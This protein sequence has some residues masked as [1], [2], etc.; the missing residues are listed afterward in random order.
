MFWYLG[1]ALLLFASGFV[2]FCLTPFWEGVARRLGVLDRPGPHKHQAE[3]VPY[4]GGMAMAGGFLAVMAAGLIGARL[5][6]AGVLPAPP[7]L[8]P[9]DLAG[10][11]LVAGKLAALL[12]G[13]LAM[14]LL[15]LADDLCSFKPSIKLIA[16]IV[17]CSIVA[18]FYRATFFAA[19]PLVG[20]LLTVGWLVVVTNIVNLLD[21]TDGAAA[22]ICAISALAFGAAAL[23]GG[24]W[25]VG[26]ALSA[27]AG[28]A[29]GFLPWNWHPARI[30][31]GDAG[32]LWLGFTI[33]SLAVLNTYYTYGQATP[34]AAVL[35][36]FVLAVPLFDSVRVVVLRMA[37][38][39]PVWQGDRRHLAHRL[40]EMGLPVGRA[41]GVLYLLTLATAAPALLL[42][43]LSWGGVACLGLQA[44]SVLLLVWAIEGGTAP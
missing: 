35:P 37:H 27:V 19:H 16:Q 22:G 4:L 20:Y 1:C 12:L 2:S 8:S 6:E 31:M 10:V 13:G 41:V 17:I 39:V 5:L 36:V 42:R 23:G 18:I 32:S 26:A 38:G 15:G 44:G 29:L 11:S 34:A 14:L 40:I 28:A 33:G 9:P 24:H 7:G 21:N 3:P 43:S 30:Y 25:F